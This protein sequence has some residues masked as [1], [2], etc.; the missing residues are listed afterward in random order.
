[1]HIAMKIS[2]LITRFL[3]SLVCVSILL[4]SPGCSTTRIVTKYDCNSIANNP[5]NKKTTWT[6]AWGLVQPKDIDPK[7]DANFNHMNQ[8]VVKTNLAFILLST[9]T[10]GIVIPQRVE[11]C[12]APAEIKPETLGKP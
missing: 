4:A 3:G 11:W 2:L 5:L 1:M 10:L 7:C 9:V 8:V 6:F 12:C